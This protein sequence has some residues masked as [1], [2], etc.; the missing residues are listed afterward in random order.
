M[1]FGLM[2]VLRVQAYAE[3]QTVTFAQHAM[4]VIYTE[5]VKVK[6]VPTC[7]GEGE[8]V[9]SSSNTEIATVDQEGEV[10]IL[11]IGV[12]TITAT[13]QAVPGEYEEA[14]D[15]Y[16]LTIKRKQDPLTFAATPSAEVP[17]EAGKTY[18]C[19]ATG[20]TTSDPIVYTSS[21]GSI[22]SVD[23]EGTITINDVGGPVTI[24]ASKPATDEYFRVEASY[25]LT[26]VPASD[27]LSFDLSEVEAKG[28]AL[29]TDG[30]GKPVATI[31]YEGALSFTTAASGGAGTGE[32]TYASSDMTVATVDNA[33]LVSVVKPGTV[34]ITATRAA[35]AHYTQTTASY[36]LIVKKMAQSISFL[37]PGVSAKLGSSYEGQ[38]ATYSG[39][40][41][42]VSYTSSNESVATV[43][44]LS[45][46]VTMVNVGTAIITATEAGNEF[47]EEASAAYVLTV[48][49]EPTPENPYTI[50]GAKLNDSGWYTGDVTFTP[51]T[52]YKIHLSAY[53]TGAHTWTDTAV[54]SNEGDQ[55]IYVY[56]KADGEYHGYTDK[57][58]QNLKIDKTAP[59]A[60]VLGF[61][62]AVTDPGDGRLFYK[63]A[64]TITI[65]AQDSVSGVKEFYY[66]YS[67]QTGGTT[68]AF[69]YV[70]GTLPAVKGAGNTYS[71]EIK[72][73]PGVTCYDFYVIAYDVAGNSTDFSEGATT[74]IVDNTAP[75]IS[76]GYTPGE[77]Q[78]VDGVRYFNSDTELTISIAED[79]FIAEDVVIN[80]TKGGS[81][82]A[83]F[84]SWSNDTVND[85]RVCTIPL[86]EET[87]YAFAISYTDRSGNAAEPFE[88]KLIVDKTAPTREAEYPEAVRILD[89]DGNTVDPATYD[90]KVDEEKNYSLYYDKET[91]VLFRITEQNFFVDDLDFTMKKDG[92]DFTPDVTWSEES[93]GVQLATI[94]LSEDGAYTFEVIYTDRAKN[95]ML[96]YV[97]ETLIVDTTDPVISVGYSGG[98]PDY[99]LGGVGYYS[100]GRTLIVTITERNFRAYDVAAAFTALDVTGAPAGVENYA[101]ILKNP[102]A[103][104]TDGDKHTASFT[105]SQDANY[106]FALDYTDLAGHAAKHYGTD[107]FTV[108][109]TPP[110]N[111]KIDYSTNFIKQFISAITFNY[112]KT[113]VTVT[114]SA[115]DS[116]TPI[117][118]F[119]YSYKKADGVSS[120]NTELIDA[121]IAEADI[122]RSGRTNTAT[123]TI[124]MDALGPTTQFNGSVNF[125]AIDRAGNASS[126]D[127]RMNNR[128][129]VD[130]ISPTRTVEYSSSYVVNSS[131]HDV[132]A[133]DSKEENK[134]YSLLYVDGATVLLH[135]NEANFYPEDISLAVTK[136]GAP[137]AASFAWTHE[138]PDNHTGKLV[139][140]EEGDYSFT[141]SY[142]DRS[143]NGMTT[144]TS[145]KLIVDRTAP[146]ISVSYSNSKVMQEADGRKYFNAAQTATITVIEKHFRAEDVAA[147]IAAEGVD[148]ASVG[149]TDFAAYLKDR[150]NWTT[151]GDKH[152]ATVNF[153]ADANYSLELDCSDLSRNKAAHY[154]PD[155]FTVDTTPPTNLSI[156]YS[157]N[158]FQQVVSAVTFGYYNDRV[159]VTIS[160][161][162]A[163]TPISHFQYSYRKAAGVS[164]VN[165]E[166]IDQ[167]IQ[168]AAITRNGRV[169][170][171][172]FT[173]PRE[174]L[175]P[176]NQFNGTVGF[177]AYD[178]AENTAELQDTVRLVVDNISPTG[179]VTFNEPIRTE[180]K[181]SYYS[182]D[183]TA[184]ISITEANF[185]SGDVAVTVTKDGQNVP[186]K[187]E[188]TDQSTDAHTGTMTLSEEG[189]YFI[190][191]TY[192]DR[193]R[194][195][196]ATYRSE[197]ITIDKTNPTITVS[198]IRNNSANKDTPYTF[199]I[200]ANDLNAD[201]AS[202]K[203]LLKLVRMTDEGTFET[204]QV[205]VDDLVTIEEGKTYAFTVGDLP[206]DGL[207]TLSC[208]VGDMA[209][210]TSSVVALEDG[211]SYDKVRF[212]I[213][214]K[215]SVFALGTEYG[216]Y[217]LDQYYVY[218]IYEDLVID[219]VNVDPISNYKVT[220]NGV[221]IPEGS[222]LTTKQT[223]NEGE[224]SKR[225]YILDKSLFD[226]EGEY[227]I[228]IESVD[229][230]GTKAFSDVKSLTFTFVVDQTAPVVTISGLES[231]G[232]YRTEEQTVTLI[233]T[234]DGGRLQSLQI[235]VLDSDGQPLKAEDGS[236]ISVRFNMQGQEL[237][238]YLNANGGLVSFTVPTGYH[239][240]V[241]I[242]CRD[243]AADDTGKT[244][245]YSETFDRVTV[246]QNQLVIFFANKPLF[247]G[248]IGGAAGLAGLAIALVALKKK[249]KEQKAAK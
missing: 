162:D 161:E 208:S 123:F 221:E 117:R 223:S 67:V 207:Y 219:E 132:A 61:P 102:S 21:N 241:S 96:D 60:P 73:E 65:T 217:L 74:V 151:D 94:K 225:S 23:T 173:I 163:T 38:T 148:G 128:V 76:A 226:A 107:S 194:N 199:T 52:N 177:S 116:T 3:A 167:A 183:V 189:D 109:T 205:P 31:T 242:I 25:T 126:L 202:F 41:G 30:S 82:F 36:T 35:D 100:K 53:Q 228:V 99:T 27:T 237:L 97:S 178:R 182:G 101:L 243:C 56:L 114:I 222:G 146:V 239:N 89:E 195:A 172:T 203:P 196:M 147:V 79:C 179:K 220:V 64:C 143:G 120:V 227:A 58:S 133:Y 246:S 138:G 231:G 121:T 235:L 230:A 154:G 22:V 50:S 106:T 197:Q 150:S 7:T 77:V 91:I 248:S 229:K 236:D 152:T 54:W 9:Y 165:A 193:S 186:V 37:N 1:L 175:G 44:S 118:Q 68:I 159:T 240:Q 63:D 176:M 187:V 238:D 160:A 188:W 110:T 34:I 88:D 224:W 11:T 84:P 98:A 49:Y 93:P 19:P 70:S 180:N 24:T 127:D 214:R 181:I 129:I 111:L 28:G 218:S 166:L 139:L 17:F 26:V 211:N 80:E 157:A 8:L 57:I 206:D 81:S 247:F 6:Q 75:V 78:T 47:Y 130:N 46:K 85:L 158:V 86:N 134:G 136:D 201:P 113:Y 191:V 124:P 13:K 155:H 164:G 135:I 249:K 192:A 51:L 140:T 119:V 184:T 168:E 112:Y 29:S 55:D 137:Y 200:T 245:E 185:Y 40:T 15:S 87:D 212:S 92:K 103:W 104:T 209:G 14:S 59:T 145:E 234:D 170:T 141:V 144:Y 108:D 69:D 125:T 115:E 90:S 244:C 233:P 43:D 42:D 232:R 83:V 122:T 62:T 48:D 156:S 20:G 18:S 169:N 149:V 198:A 66:S 95:E 10:S 45:G 105:I 72:I 5:G 210:H 204:I 33:G 71:A 174:A 216:E 32:I 153:S 213:N 190:T 142:A 12:V 171:A 2:P 131:L 215:G 39:G 4:D 16:T